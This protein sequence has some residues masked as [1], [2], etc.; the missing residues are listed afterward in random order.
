MK[1]TKEQLK[2]LI[3]EELLKEAGPETIEEHRLTTAWQSNKD[4]KKMLEDLNYL[5]LI[6]SNALDISIR[7]IQGLAGILSTARKDLSAW[8]RGAPARQKK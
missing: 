8:G 5:G 1:I 7:H 4:L 2:A 6:D 3:K